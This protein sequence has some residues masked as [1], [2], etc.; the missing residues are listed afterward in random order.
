MSIPGSYGFPGMGETTAFARGPLDFVEERALQ[1]GTVFK[2]NLVGRKLVFVTAAAEALQV[3]DTEAQNFSVREGYEEFLRDL[4]RNNVILE[5]PATAS[6]LRSGLCEALRRERLEALSAVLDPLCRTHAQHLVASGVTPVYEKIKHAMRDAT[7]VIL[8]GPSGNSTWLQQ[9]ATLIRTHFNGL[10]S[11]P[12]NI[13][14][15]GLKGGFSKALKARDELLQQF[16]GVVR[17]RATTLRQDP[18]SATS[19]VLDTLLHTLLTPDVDPGPVMA[20]IAQQLLLLKCSVVEKCLASLVT[21]TL[22]E[23]SAP[24]SERLVEQLRQQATTQGP[25][26]SET[27]R[28]LMKETARLHPATVGVMRRVPNEVKCASVGPHRVDGGT[29]VWICVPT[30]NRDPKV[31]ATPLRFLPGKRTA[32]PH[33]TVAH[34]TAHMTRCEPPR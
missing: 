22:W 14:L 27:C 25:E 19:C 15:P 18:A 34:G 23:L 1:Y 9:M 4:F 20:E 8:F 12:F 32:T 17:H 28:A 13:R 29:R 30:V 21:F 10:Q 31:F 24:G 16:E 6:R 11:L 3:L 33:P 2:T 26:W 7:D 5:C